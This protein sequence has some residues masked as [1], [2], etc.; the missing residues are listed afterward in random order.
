MVLLGS[1]SPYLVK[2]APACL[3]ISSGKPVPTTRG[4]PTASLGSWFPHLAETTMHCN[5][6]DCVSSKRRASG[7]LHL[8]HPVCRQDRYTIN[9]P[10]PRQPPLSSLSLKHKL[11][12]LAAP[13]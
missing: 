6:L 2:L 3:V 12:C 10:K 9:T 13:R 11:T 4:R 7:G 5:T 8:G 1:H